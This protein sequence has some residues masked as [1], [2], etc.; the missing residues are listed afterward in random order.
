MQSIGDVMESQPNEDPRALVIPT[1]QRRPTLMMNTLESFFG[2][3]LKKKMGLLQE[4]EPIF[5]EEI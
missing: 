4:E 3:T 2:Q 5:Q 1:Q